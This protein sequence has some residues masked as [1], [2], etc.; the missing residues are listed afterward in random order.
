MYGILGDDMALL[1]K[2]VSPLRVDSN[3]PTFSTDSLSLK[4]N[5]RQRSGQRWEVSARLEP[6]SASA[7]VLFALIVKKGS[8][9]I[10]NLV[11]PQN[12]GAVKA[13]RPASNA[14]YATGT[15]N[16]SFAVVQSD[17]FIPVGT[18]IQFGQSSKVYLTV[19]EA[20]PLGKIEIVPRL[21]DTFNNVPFNWKDDVIMKAYLDQSNVRGMAFEDGI[22][23]DNG[24][25]SFVERV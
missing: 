14:E 15:V 6:L 22:L 16:D 2:F 25:L 19:S 23:M 20:T 1:A 7:N 11:V 24:E 4:R 9:G 3:V 17:S 8:T 18:F 12:Y 5:T 21:Q 13:R 10:Y